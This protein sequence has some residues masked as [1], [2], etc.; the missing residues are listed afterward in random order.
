MAG[1][2]NGLCGGD[3]PPRRRRPGANRNRAGILLTAFVFCACSGGS[4]AADG[5]EERHA[6][7]GPATTGSMTDAGI[8][9]LVALINGTEA[10]SAKAV[11]P[12]LVMPAVRA[13][14]GTLMADHTRL[15]SSMPKFDGPRVAPPQ[16]QTLNAIFHSQAAMLSTLPAGYAFDATFVAVQV[17]DHVM[18]IDSLWRWRDAT[19]DPELRRA[20]GNAIP[21]ME[22]HLEQAR[23]LYAR[24]GG[25]VDVA[26]A[27]R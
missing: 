3:D 12:K 11:Q 18:A 21:V 9:A 4:D 5:N 10:G 26:G 16:A 24:L 13:Y 2:E 25:L 6:P 7:G 19:D 14:A 20:L 22:S 23:A 27:G 17:V 8:A 15:L 1:P